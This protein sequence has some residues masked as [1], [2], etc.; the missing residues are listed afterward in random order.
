MEMAY[1]TRFKMREADHGDGDDLQQN[2]RDDAQR[3]LGEYIGL[4]FDTKIDGSGCNSFV[5]TRQ[6]TE[7]NSSQ[8]GTF[9]A[10]CLRQ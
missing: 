9:A 4:Q 10:D 5:S 6:T 3:P 1:R 8:I 2:T 7:P